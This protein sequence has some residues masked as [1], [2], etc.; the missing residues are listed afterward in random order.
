MEYKEK[1]I[2][3]HPGKRGKGRKVSIRRGSGQGIEGEDRQS[4]R[5]K[6]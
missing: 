6:D 3:W 1:R 2:E 5:R 4:E